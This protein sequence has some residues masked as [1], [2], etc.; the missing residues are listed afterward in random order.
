MSENNQ[1][2]TRLNAYTVTRIVYL[3]IEEYMKNNLPK[4]AGVNLNYTY[5]KDYTKSG[6]LL[7]IG[8]NWRTKDMSKVPAIFV[9]R[10]EVTYKTPSMGQANASVTGNAQTP[11]VA[12]ATM[13]V[14]V[15]CIAPAP[16]AQ[17]ESLAEYVKQPLLW[18]RNDIQ[19]LFG[20][21]RFQLVNI[22]KPKLLEESKTNF[23][24]DLTL[25]ITFDDGW[26]ISSEN[27]L[28][29]HIVIDLIA[30]DT[31]LLDEVAPI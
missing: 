31:T 17:V 29:K 13:P 15:S 24:I 1:I 4:D 9:Q 16:L 2:P 3:V 30:P 5:D 26:I 19:A 23:F 12:F 21:R 25:N 7:D 22:S 28:I 6:I 20:I 27:P 11:R 10:E 14:T 8:Y 18:L